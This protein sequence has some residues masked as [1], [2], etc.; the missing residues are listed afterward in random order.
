MNCGGTVACGG[1]TLDRSPGFVVDGSWVF[2]APPP[3]AN[4]TKAIE[5]IN[6]SLHLLERKA[7]AV[8]ARLQL[9]C[10]GSNFQQDGRGVSIGSK[11]IEAS[12]RETCES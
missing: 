1:A 2:A 7:E 5:Q 9:L 10:G 11:L 12:W 8:A 6:S 3:H 4:A